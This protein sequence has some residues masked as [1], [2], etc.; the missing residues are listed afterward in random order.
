[1][2]LN[3]FKKKEPQSNQDKES[4]VIVAM[5]LF[6]N[7]ETYDI[8]KVINH[9]KTFW[10]LTISDDDAVSNDTAVFN[11]NGQMVAIA[12]MPAPIPRDELESVAPYNYMWRSA[13][14]DLENHTNHAIVSVLST[15][16]PTV[17]RFTILSKILCS[18]L[19]TSNCV[20]VYQGMQTLLLSCNYYLEF[21]DDL[22]DGAVCIPLWVY[23]GIRHENN[24]TSLYTYG[25]A[26]F[27]KN[28]MEIIN[29]E[30]DIEELYNF[31]L[32]ISSYVVSENVTLKHG[33]TIGYTAT[34]KIPIKLSQGV[35]LPD[36]QTLKFEM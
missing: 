5:P 15:D 18:I 33:E 19:A 31:I 3:F 12:Q 34:Q 25:M 24:K 21:V 13:L 36:K 32:N 10:Q 30:I 2:A 26:S 6:N 16:L 22:K 23:I 9:L 7:N 35:F 4:D 27:G 11:V 8:I 1:M 28:E 14:Q 17:D 29:S 20:G